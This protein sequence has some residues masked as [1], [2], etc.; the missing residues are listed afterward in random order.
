MPPPRAH[1]AGW[2]PSPGEEVEAR[3]L[4]ELLWKMEPRELGAGG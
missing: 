2:V 4:L 3:T 1:I